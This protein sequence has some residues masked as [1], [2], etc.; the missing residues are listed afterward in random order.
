M[1]ILGRKKKKEKNERKKKGIPDIQHQSRDIKFLKHA[2]LTH[3]CAHAAHTHLSRLALFS[4]RRGWNCLNARERERERSWLGKETIN[5][6]PR[7]NETTW[8]W[9]PR[10]GGREG[11]PG[12]NNSFCG[13]KLAA[14][15]RKRT[16]VAHGWIR[17]RD[18][19]PRPEILHRQRRARNEPRIPA[20]ES[21]GAPARATPAFGTDCQIIFAEWLV[22]LPSSLSLSSPLRSKRRLPA[23]LSK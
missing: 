23:F 13:A 11:R 7:G 8:Q 15:F 6:F 18:P 1:L 5:T 16:G 10:I 12:F 19:T 2:A 17:R 20:V 9:S 22:K 3:T 4:R 14:I 21:D